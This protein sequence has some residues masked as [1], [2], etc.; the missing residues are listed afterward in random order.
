MGLRVSSTRPASIRLDRSRRSMI[1][2]SSTVRRSM[3]AS[4]LSR[5][6]GSGSGS[7]RRVAAKPLMTVSGVRSSCDAVARNRVLASSAC[8]TLVMSRSEW[9]TSTE[10]SAPSTETAL[11]SRGCRRPSNPARHTSRSRAESPESAPARRAQ[12]WEQSRARSPIRRPSTSEQWRPIS[13]PS[14]RPSRRATAGLHCTARLAP[15]VTSTPSAMLA[16]MASD[17]PSRRFERATSRR[18][19]LA[20]RSRRRTSATSTAPRRAAAE[21]SSPEEGASCS[22]ATMK[23]RAP[24]ASHE[25]N[26]RPAV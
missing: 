13:S 25:A 4:A 8:F 7:P 22:A 16:R 18:C 19:T 3:A 1:L 21:L 10:P 2:V 11:A 17:R 26:P 15:S 6:A 5:I 24:A 12:P 14:G 20:V 23:V 9:T